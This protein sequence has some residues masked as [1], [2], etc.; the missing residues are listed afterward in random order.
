[1]VSEK[2]LFHNIIKSNGYSLTKSRQAVFDVLVNSSGPL[3][4]NELSKILSKTANRSSVYRTLELFEKLN[5]VR[6]VQTGWKY[7]IELSEIFKPHHHH[8]TCSVCGR[9]SAIE[10]NRD[11]ELMLHTMAKEASYKMTNHT[12]ELEGICSIC[13]SKS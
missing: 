9:I 2:T 7:K 1:M 11:M 6:R 12:L 10:E 13:Q 4:I 3:S 8:I 5:I